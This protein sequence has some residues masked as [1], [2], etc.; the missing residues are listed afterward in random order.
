MR[1]AIA[2]IGAAHIDRT[3]HALEQITMGSSN[4]VRVDIA[5]GG[6]ARNVAENLARLGC[7]VGLVSRLGRDDDGDRLIDD[8]KSLGIQTSGIC[9]SDFEDTA[10]Y[11][12]LID[13]AGEMTVGMA[14]MSI[15]DEVAPE[16]FGANLS[17]DLLARPI[18]FLDTNLPADGLDHL[19]QR[20][21]A[22]CL[23]AIDA[24]SVAKA[25][26]LNG[27]LGRVDLL[28]VNHSEAE[29]LCGLPASSSAD[30]RELAN[31]LRSDGAGTVIVA[32]GDDGA[33]IAADS[34]YDFYDPLPTDVCDVT[35]AGDGMVSGILYGIAVGRPFS[36]AVRLGLAC[37]SL[38][39]ES[40][41]SVNEDLR[42]PVLLRRAGLL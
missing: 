13:L 22:N 15:Y 30:V 3:A 38:S 33:F 12:A 23:A 25:P 41:R 31:R 26:R 18:W 32:M 4:P 1:S 34:V 40:D 36:E 7:D 19:L 21:P 42:E 35:G 24:V 27:L 9:R 8:L 39:I 37:A 16:L 28:F 14:D 2:C 10:S 11:T 6:V 29:A 17:P 5:F 20:K